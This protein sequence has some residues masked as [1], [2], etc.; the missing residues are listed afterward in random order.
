MTILLNVQRNKRLAR[1]LDHQVPRDFRL[2]Y[3]LAELEAVYD[4]SGGLCAICG[5]T[6]SDAK[7][8]LDHCHATGRLRGLLCRR[9]NTGVGMLGDDPARLRA[10]ADYLERTQ[11]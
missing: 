9:C 1:A 7:H 10:A 8:S 5:A 4:A 3:T 11:T 2:G 6:E